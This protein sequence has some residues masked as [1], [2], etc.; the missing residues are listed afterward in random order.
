MGKDRQLRRPR[1]ART[2]ARN[3][4]VTL[5]ELMVVVVMM[6]V[7]AAIA[8]PIFSR[9]LRQDDALRLANMIAKATQQ[10]RTRALSTQRSQIITI[11]PKAITFSFRD[12]GGAVHVDQT[13]SAPAKARV[14][15]VVSAQAA[16]TA[17]QS[18]SHRI[19][20]RPD[21]TQSLDGDATKLNAF[22]YVAGNDQTKQGR[23]YQVIILAGVARVV[24][25]W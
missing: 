15:S 5:T 11:A 6:G 25:A 18:A 24:D 14:W 4:G 3:R 16:P 8:V 23:G 7:L 2:L 17:P 22:V 13:T 12:A 1:N 20:F 10:A 21:L 19:E 9:D